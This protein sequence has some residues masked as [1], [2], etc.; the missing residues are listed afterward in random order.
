M[1]RSQPLPQL[2][3]LLLQAIDGLL[4]LAYRQV[5]LM[6]AFFLEGEPCLKFDDAFVHRV[7]Q[8]RG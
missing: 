4:L 6:D 8:G 5:Q 2:F 7:I 1:G 3:E